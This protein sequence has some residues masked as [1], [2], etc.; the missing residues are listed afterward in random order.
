MIYSR[1]HPQLLDHSR[2]TGASRHLPW[3]INLELL[4]YGH[5]AI[6]AALG[7]DR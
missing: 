5:A 6:D 1:K 4:D 3:A 7:I 2:R